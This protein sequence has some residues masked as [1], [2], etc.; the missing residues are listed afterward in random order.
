MINAFAAQMM[1]RDFA[2]SDILLSTK[3]QRKRNFPWMSDKNQDMMD[4]LLTT[5]HTT[6]IPSLAPLPK[7]QHL[8]K[9]Q[10][11]PQ[12]PILPQIPLQQTRRNSLPLQPI[13]QRPIQPPIL[14]QSIPEQI[15]RH[16]LPP[17]PTQGTNPGIPQMQTYGQHQV[18]PMTIPETMSY[19]TSTQTQNSQLPNQNS[20]YSY[21]EQHQILQPQSFI[22]KQNINKTDVEYMTDSHQ[23]HPKYTRRMSPNQ[24]T[25]PEHPQQQQT[26]QDQRTFPEYQNRPSDQPLGNPNFP[27]SSTLPYQN[28][29]PSSYGFS[30]TTENSM[31]TEATSVLENFFRTPPRETH[32]Q[33]EYEDTRG[34]T[35]PRASHHDMFTESDSFDRQ[36]RDTSS[37]S[38]R[39]RYDDNGYSGPEEFRGRRMIPSLMRF[40]QV[41]DPSGQTRLRF[42]NNKRRPERYSS[43]E[44]TFDDGWRD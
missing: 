33:D 37:G 19:R 23:T 42:A 39:K 18:P 34:D 2:L 35:R 13:Q 20:M 38:S 10:A 16:S 5:V 30:Q 43:N 4:K 17:P 26:F 44:R 27:Q 12:Q 14:P 28:I 40:E 24:R 25:Y 31:V 21:P 15:R 8:M 6:K 32:S 41:G 3:E 29:N 36:S 11:V 9:T 7:V 1:L 22:Q